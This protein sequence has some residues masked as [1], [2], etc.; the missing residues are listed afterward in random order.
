MVI[1]RSTL[2]DHTNLVDRLFEV[3]NVPM[4][5]TVVS[6]FLF[7]LMCAKAEAL[8]LGA[9]ISP[10]ILRFASNKLASFCRVYKRSVQYLRGIFSKI[11]VRTFLSS[12]LLSFAPAKKV[13]FRKW[14]QDAKQARKSDNIRCFICPSVVWRAVF[15]ILEN[16]ITRCGCIVFEI[17]FIT[18]QGCNAYHVD[19]IRAVHWRKLK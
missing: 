14:P 8:H 9:N 12:F 5:L 11:S 15:R 2:H 16:H 1:F 6:S 10:Y 18:A 17:C 13:Q 7:F 4:E 19:N 3:K